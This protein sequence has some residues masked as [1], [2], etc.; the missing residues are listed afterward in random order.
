MGLNSHLQCLRNARLRLGVTT[1]KTGTSDP[2]A[3]PKRLAPEQGNSMAW[4]AQGHRFSTSVGMLF[5]VKR[6]VQNLLKKRILQLWGPIC[7]SNVFEMHRWHLPLR[8]GVT[9]GK[10]TTSDPK[11][12]PKRLAPEQGNSMAWRAQG[13]R[14]STCVGMI[15]NVKRC[16]QNL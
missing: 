5:N 14:F 9:T 1:G 3:F 16:V 15:F 10:T 6:R 7:T 12:F 11:A 2:K 4:R 13:H 8:L